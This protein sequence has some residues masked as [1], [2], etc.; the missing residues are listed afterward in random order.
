MRHHLFEA[1]LLVLGLSLT[2]FTPLPV[3]P[4]PSAN[5]QGSLLIAG[6]LETFS[7][8]AS[9]DAGGTVSGSFE[10]K[11]RGI[12]QD[13][14]LHGTI[15]CMTVMPD[16]KTAFLAG[17]ITQREG[18]DAYPNSYLVGD[19][20]YFAVKDKGEGQNAMEDQFS[21]VF[22]SGSTEVCGPHPTPLYPIDNGNIQVKP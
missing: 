21:D 20:V 17:L 1:T 7:F 9:T 13:M 10:V 19:Y 18:G 3:P 4:G 22:A 16:G 14:R 15:T 5:G 2:S 12:G 6:G 11:G 8:H